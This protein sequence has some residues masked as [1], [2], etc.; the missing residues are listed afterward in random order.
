M[1]KCYNLYCLEG[2]DI[3]KVDKDCGFECA[4][5]EECSQY[6][7][8]SEELEIDGIEHIWG[9]KSYDDLSGSEESTLYTMNDIELCRI[10]DKEDE[11]FGK[12]LL[13]VETIYTFSGE[14][15]QE[16]Y[17]NTAGYLTILLT[18]FTEFCEEN[19]I[20]THYVPHLSFVFTNNVGGVSD[21]YFNSI[22]EAYAVF[23]VFVNGY[24]SL[25][26]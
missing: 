16:Q 4:K 6:M 26:E 25:I 21:Y 15:I 1:K 22:E 19:G 11:H 9:L 23:K 3:D 10:T 7:Q 5:C 14:T 12:Y 2:Y 18:K 13:S 17:K 20:D 8:T 24:K